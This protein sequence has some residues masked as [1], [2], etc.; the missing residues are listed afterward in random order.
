[1]VPCIEGWMW[2]VYAYVPAAAKVRVIDTFVLL[3]AMSAGAP[4]CWVKKTLCGT[5]PNANVTV[6]PTFTGSVPGVKVR[7]G[8]AATVLPSGGG[9]AGPPYLPPH[10]I[11][12]NA[13]GQGARAR[14]ET[15][16]ASCR[17][18]V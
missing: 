18:K 16:R 3:P 2:Q 11:A 10:A 13:A 15:G 1:M 6:S 17:G 12:S 8:V 4:V 9:P 14:P 5:D 7:D